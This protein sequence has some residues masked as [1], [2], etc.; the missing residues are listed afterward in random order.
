MILALLW[1]LCL[2]PVY[3]QKVHELCRNCHTEQFEDFQKHKHFAKGLSCDACHG[4][5][6][7]HR[8][9]NG[10]AP[11]DRVAAADQQPALCGACH[12]APAKAYSSS[13]HGQLVLA[14][15]EK[16]AA[17]C[18]LCHGIHAQRTSEQMKAQCERCHAQLV[19]GHP[20]FAAQALCVSC[21][22]GHTL[23]AKK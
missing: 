8:A 20:K 6:A 10:A 3:A 1:L 21:H 17:S 23:L 9:A 19:P 5:S 7:E 4:P 12:P 22:P 13:K 16:K 11:P 18:T 14:R 15:S 2:V